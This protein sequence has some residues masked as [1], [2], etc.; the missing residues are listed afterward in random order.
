MNFLVLFTLLPLAFAAPAAEVR[1]VTPTVS[2][3]FPKATIIGQPGAVEI[4]P[5][6]P[7][8]KAPVGALRLKP[9]QAITQPFTYTASGNGKACP[10]FV[11]STVKNDAIPTSVLG[12][13]LN[14]P[15]FQTALNTGE[16]C[17]NINVHRPE[18][19]KAGESVSPNL[20][21]EPTPPLFL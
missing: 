20:H 19:T 15:L 7:F 6:I 4:F 3:A 18:G 11:F 9:P 2:L 12:L 17:L 10:Q 14:T 13:L 21:Y 5:G 16:D 1:A 8:A